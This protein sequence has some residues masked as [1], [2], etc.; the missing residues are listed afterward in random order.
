MFSTSKFQKIRLAVWLLLASLSAGEALALDYFID[1]KFTVPLGSE[2][3]E[4]WYFGDILKYN[5]ATGEVTYEVA[6][7]RKGSAWW[8]PDLA[9]TSGVFQYLSSLPAVPLAAN[10]VPEFQTSETIANELVAGSNGYRISYDGYRFWPFSLNNPLVL[11]QWNLAAVPESYSFGAI[12]PAGLSRSFVESDIY[13]FPQLQL[14]YEV[15]EPSTLLA[16]IS[17]APLAARVPRRVR[18]NL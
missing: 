18:T 10:P 15:P 7:S 5:S 1:R 17:L 12:L 4:N 16:L 11:S 8:P 6:E 2:T 13:A 3:A 9:S 14:V